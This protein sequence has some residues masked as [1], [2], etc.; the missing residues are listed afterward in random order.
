[1]TEP[2][3]PPATQEEEVPAESIVRPDIR[4]G[5][6]EFD[7]ESGEP[8]VH[9]HPSYRQPANEDEEHVGG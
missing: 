3:N 2:E 7:E 4:G 1:M 5:A 9:E 6:L 8:H